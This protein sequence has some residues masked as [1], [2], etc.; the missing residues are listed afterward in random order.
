MPKNF[1]KLG[2]DFPIQVSKITCSVCHGLEF[3]RKQVEGL[4]NTIEL[5]WDALIWQLFVIHG[6]F[7]SLSG[8]TKDLIGRDSSQPTEKSN[9]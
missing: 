8:D 5:V 7:T 6:S 2:Q 3:G 4:L 1:S 9:T